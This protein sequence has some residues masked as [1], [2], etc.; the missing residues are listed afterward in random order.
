MPSK[1]SNQKRIKLQSG[2]IFSIKLDNEI[3]AFGRALKKIDIGFVVEIFDFFSASKSDFE[4]AIN[5]PRLFHPQIIDSHS[6]FWLRKEGDWSVEK[7]G[8]DGFTVVGAKD[9]K[10]SFGANGN[11]KLIDIFGVEEPVGDEEAKKYF[12]YGPKGDIDIKRLIKVWREKI[13]E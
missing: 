13:K 5:T 6:I 7:K 2:D 8:G 11:K 10:F 1:K 4:N 9:I 3:Y 12:G